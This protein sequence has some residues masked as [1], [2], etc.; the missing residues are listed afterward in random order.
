VYINKCLTIAEGQTLHRNNLFCPISRETNLM[1]I[2]A[3]QAVE[4]AINQ[5]VDGFVA[6]PWLHRVEHSIHCELYMLLK[7][8]PGLQ[9]KVEAKG[10]I[11][12]LVHKEWP[13]PQK[14]GLRPR[15]GNFDL[16]I[17]MQPGDSWGLDEFRYGRAPLLAAIE[18]G[19]NYSLDH[20]QG[21]TNKLS[22]SGV[23]NRYLIHLATPRCRNQKGVS[24]FVQSLIANE[25][26]GGVKVAYVDHVQH[27]QRKLGEPGLSSISL[28]PFIQ[29]VADPAIIR[30]SGGS[31]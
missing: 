26:K 3:N 10:L 2:L 21:D 6:N 31:S 22:E 19:L 29:S 23:P 14:S 11:T 5:L 20:L 8:L 24:G 16:A 12:Q 15:R 1:N 27:L 13:E 28:T 4:N 9:G 17:L 25:P 7:T 30:L 18:V